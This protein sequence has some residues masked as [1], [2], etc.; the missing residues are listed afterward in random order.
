MKKIVELVTPRRSQGL[1]LLYALAGCDFNCSLFAK[2]H[3]AWLNLYL[4]DEH[5]FKIFQNVIHQPDS[6]L[7]YFAAIE[8]FMLK[9]YNI[10]DPAIGCVKARYEKLLHIQASNP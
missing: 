5:I 2:G 10:K 3:N 4:N 6:F 7:N 9:L 1:L 8:C